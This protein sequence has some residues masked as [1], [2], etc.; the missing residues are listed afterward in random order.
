MYFEIQKQPPEV[1]YKKSAL[2]SLAIF[3]IFAT[4]LKRDSNAGV[5]LRNCKIF[6]NTYFEE[7]LRMAESGNIK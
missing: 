4:L 5:F 7:H 2:K 6:K 3:K 1:V